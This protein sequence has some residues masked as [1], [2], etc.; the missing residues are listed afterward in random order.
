MLYNIIMIAFKSRYFL[1]ILSL[2]LTWPIFAQLNLDFN[3]GNINTVEW[4]G[5]IQNFIV[6][7]RGELQLNA[8]GAGEST[9]FT[10]FKVPEDSIQADLYFRMD[11][12]PSDANQANIYLFSDNININSATGYFLRLGENGNNDAVRVFRLKNGLSTLMGSGRLGAI[13]NTPALARLQ[14]KIYR[15]GLW[16]MASDYSGRILYQDDLEFFDSDFTWP[17]SLYFGINCR[18]TA[19][20]TNLFFFDDIRIRTLEKD[21]VPPIVVQAD[22]LDSERIKISFSKIPDDISATN[23]DN[24]SLNNSVG[25]PIEVIYSIANPLEAILIF[26]DGAIRSGV[27]YSL[28]INGLKDKLQNTRPHSID[29]F[30]ISKAAIGDLKINEVLTDPITGGEDFV[31]LINVSDKF[32]SLD[33]ISI[34]NTENN[35]TRLI[36][37]DMVLKPG[38]YVA[39]SRNI[40]FLK[41]RY[42]TPDTARFIDATLPALN[43]ASANITLLV[44]DKGKEIVIDS[45]DYNQNFHFSLL[46]NNKGVSLERINPL[47][48]SN[49]R[50]NWHSA[51]ESVNFGTPGYKNSNTANTI[52][53]KDERI[54]MRPNRKIITPDGDGMDDFILLEYVLD[55]PGYLATVRLFDSEGFPMMN[56]AN[57]VLLSQSGALKWDA[58]GNEG[59]ALPL[60]MYI[61]FSRLFHPDGA[62]LESKHVIIVG[63]KF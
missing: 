38:E 6:N 31:E 55:K 49:D 16:L 18:Y 53:T 1:S 19:T 10:K 58:V 20:R 2:L 25:M 15:D 9:I 3:D 37:T 5:D 32:I 42:E 46:R 33:S 8:T 44:N 27:D 11:F 60:G 21:T 7:N 29:V 23:E 34:K 43:V 30:F 26:N 24:Y 54:I 51:V 13:A 56:I 62:V 17:D 4:Q 41:E 22:V 36:L 40:D 59:R 61:V 45:F 63:Q 48:S 14:F 57:N 35:Q 28:S 50:N 12:S 52:E 39:I 47:G